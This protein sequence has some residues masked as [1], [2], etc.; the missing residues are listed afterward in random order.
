MRRIFGSAL[1]AVCALAL[2]STTGRGEDKKVSIEGT[3]VIVGIE[4]DG[5]A[6]PDDLITKA[7]EGERT[8]KIT[9]DQLI[10]NKGGKD[11]PANYKL[12][13]SKTPYQIDMTAKNKGK[14]EKMYGIFKVDGDKLTICMIEADKADDRPK[15]FKTTSGG[16]AVIIVLQKKKK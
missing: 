1:L 6:L 13:T 7:P 2:G 3:Y 9:A 16:K 15:E 8:I 10:A 14:E 11:D 5:K 12:D 4:A